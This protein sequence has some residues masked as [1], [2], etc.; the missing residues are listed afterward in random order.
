MKQ[1]EKNNGSIFRK[2][3]IENKKKLDL[4]GNVRTYLKSNT[5]QEI[6]N[7]IFIAVV[8][9]TSDSELVK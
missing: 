1:V 4:T 3:K 9:L 7:I 2:S 5:A 8:T 6:G